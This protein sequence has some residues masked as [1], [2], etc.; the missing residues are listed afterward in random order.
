MTHIWYNHFM[1]KLDEVKEEIGWLKLMFGIFTAVD[2][3]LLGW[4][5]QHY[6]KLSLVYSILSVIA[7]LVISV[8]IVLL[9]KVP[10]KKLDS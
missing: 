5:A 9:I 10:T 8:G 7:I 1:G 4:F 2:I 3:S 6:E